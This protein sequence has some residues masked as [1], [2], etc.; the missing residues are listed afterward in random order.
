MVELPRER[1]K[2]SINEQQRMEFASTKTQTMKSV[3]SEFST[4]VDCIG[5]YYRMRGQ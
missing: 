4:S 1:E 2:V 5:Y 3:S